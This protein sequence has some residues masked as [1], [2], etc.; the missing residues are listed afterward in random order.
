RKAI[1]PLLDVLRNHPRVRGALHAYS[2]SFEQVRPL[3][4]REIYIGVGGAVTRSRAK[5]VRTCAAALP[6]DRI[7]LETDAP[8]IGMDIIEP[9]SVRPAHLPRVLQA[10]AELR[11]L[12]QG[13][14]ETITDHNAKRLFRV[15]PDTTPGKPCL[16][17][18]SNAPSA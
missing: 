7:L 10:L 3:L 8:A 1:A 2:G 14:L 5:R 15:P 11:G 4:D 17:H 18:G 12:S 6:L 9:P 13:E 16:T